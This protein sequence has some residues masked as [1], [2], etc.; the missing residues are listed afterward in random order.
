MTGG[1]EWIVSNTES[2]NSADIPTNPVELPFN[3]SVMPP[4]ACIVF[5]PATGAE[6]GISAFD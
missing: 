2:K 3:W 5:F 1:N 6:L 4:V